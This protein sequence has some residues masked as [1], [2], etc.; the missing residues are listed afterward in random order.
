MYQISVIEDFFDKSSVISTRVYELA[1]HFGRDVF[2]METAAQNIRP[3]IE[4]V[5][6]VLRF[7][8]AQTSIQIGDAPID[9]LQI[10]IGDLLLRSGRYGLKPTEAALLPVM[11][12]L[13]D[14]IT[15]VRRL[16]KR[17][18][19]GEIIHDVQMLAAAAYRLDDE[20]I[21]CRKRLKAD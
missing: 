1:Q 20:L 2:S 19:A 4:D 7:G 3:L 8:L 18:A 16:L 5:G 13:V 14:V 12:R 21:E 10:G 15:E 17:M 6:D 11:M 9:D